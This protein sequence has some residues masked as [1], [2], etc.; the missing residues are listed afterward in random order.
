MEHTAH[1]AE[2]SEELWLSQGKVWEDAPPKIRRM[3]QAMFHIPEFVQDQILPSP[4]LSI[5]K[6]LQFTLPRRHTSTS[7]LHVS[8][9]FRRDLPGPITTDAISSLRRLPVPSIALVRKL[10]DI[11]HQAWLNGYQSITYAHL[12][13]FNSSDSEPVQ[14]LY[15]PWALTFWG[16]IIRHR[17]NVREPWLTCTDWLQAQT[18]QKKSVTL[19]RLAEDANVILTDLPWGRNKLG[20]S[21]LEPIHS[22]HRYLGTSWTTI[23]QQNDM[24]E[25]LRGQIALRPDLIRSLAVEGVV[26]TETIMAA[27]DAQDKYLTDRRFAWIRHLGGAIILTNQALLTVAHVV[28]H[29]VALV[30]DVKERVIRYGDSFG[31]TIPD[32]ML[33][34]YKWWLAQHTKETFKME[35]LPMTRQT[36]TH[37]CGYLAN[38]GLHFFAIPESF[39]LIEPGVHAGAS[40]RITMF[41]KLAEHILERVSCS[42]LRHGH[43]ADRQQL[44]EDAARACN[45]ESTLKPKVLPTMPETARD[46]SM[47]TTN[48]DSDFK[49]ENTSPLSAAAMDEAC[50]IDFT[51]GAAIFDQ[52]D[53]P[54]DDECL[55]WPAEHHSGH[56]NAPRTQTPSPDTKHVQTELIESIESRDKPH[57]LTVLDDA[58]VPLNLQVTSP[59]AGDSEDAFGSPTCPHD[60]ISNASQNTM[61]GAK[62]VDLRDYWKVET[63]KEKEERH[64]REWERLERDHEARAFQ[65]EQGQMYRRNKVRA[66]NRERAQRYRDLK[67]E[68][69][70][71]AGWVPGQKRVSVSVLI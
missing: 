8:A 21:D 29:R 45:L 40:A 44:S 12:D 68:K 9:F 48:E 64:H 57:L 67:R 54:M 66:G 63:A 16:E 24:L 43:L 6:M 5:C 62:K 42:Y 13:T 35:T 39:P 4:A 34:A 51:F 20:L 14:T 55:M 56:T 69:K 27:A 7:N 30:I 31:A 10:E 71:E 58:D 38:N 17:I 11:G 46:S 59:D 50:S 3:G 41:N 25:L 49:M 33:H 52:M 65:D 70:I 28:N 18:K 2:T 22:M 19:K 26:L 60:N 15:P 32:N 53:S 47:A 37:S 23:S 1:L 61:G 36:D